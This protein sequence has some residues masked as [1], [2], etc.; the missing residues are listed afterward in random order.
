MQNLDFADYTM[1][2]IVNTIVFPSIM[3]HLQSISGI[4]L[5]FVKWSIP[6]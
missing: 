4:D 3:F 2:V 5:G 6:S 1:V